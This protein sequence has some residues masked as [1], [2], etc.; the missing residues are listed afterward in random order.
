[1]AKLRL[2][3]DTNI[4]IDLLADR[5]PFSNS[6]YVLFKE[7][8]LKRWKLFTS[9]NS[10]LTTIYIVEKQLN[11]NNIVFATVTSL[12]APLLLKNYAK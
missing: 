3:I 2:F 5:K 4:I 10:M 1:M 12:I 11:P 8:K 7:A 9:S 6:A